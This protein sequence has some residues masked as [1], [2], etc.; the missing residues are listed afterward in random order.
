MKFKKLNKFMKILQKIRNSDRILS[1]LILFSILIIMIVQ[2]VLRSIFNIL[3]VGVE[4]LSRYLFISVVFMGLPYY[5]RI[6]GHIKLEGIQKYLPQKIRM[7]IDIIIQILSFFVFAIIAFSA[8]YTTLTNYNSAT[9]TISI[10]F[11][12]F[13]LPTILGFTLLSIE[14]LNILIKTIKRDTSGWA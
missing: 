13:F 2:I 4:E 9:P 12:L 5:Y 1:T 8:L 14:H 10:P 3:F 6:D 11:W 7:I